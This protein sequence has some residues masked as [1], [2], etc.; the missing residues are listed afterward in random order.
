MQ[1]RTTSRRRLS[2]PPAFL[3]ALLPAVLPA[4]MLA[5][6][7]CNTN[8]IEGL[9]PTDGEE[10]MR[11]ETGDQR[12]GR[13]DS[14]CGSIK[15]E[16]TL[17]K[18]PVDIIFIIDNSGSMADEAL[19]VNNNINNNFANIIAASGLDYRVIMVT[20][21]GLYN[22]A[23]T[24]A[25]CVTKPLSTLA[26]CSPP[27]VQPGNNPPK[28]FHYSRQIE[29]SDSFTRLLNTYGGATPPLE[30]DEFNLAPGGWAM[31][32]RP[33]AFKVFI[34]ITDDESG[35]QDTVFE[36]RLFALMPKHFGDA[37]KRNYIFHAITGLIEN[38]PPTKPW[39]PGD[40]LQTVKCTK[41]GGAVNAGQI[42][43]K[44]AIATGGL[45]FPICE[46]AAFDGIFKEIANGVITGAK[47][48]CDFP[49]PEAP[50]GQTIDLGSVIVD[51]TPM[52]TG[53]PVEY[54][55]VGN[56]A[57]CV[58]NAFYIDKGRIYLCPDTCFGVQ[59]D[60]MAKLD[61]T[62]DCNFG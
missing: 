31:W 6:S 35:M 52:G 25:I 7:G 36:G 55:Q 5:S 9:E 45:R 23:S 40:P 13:N 39:G 44:L 33:E 42:Y 53:S 3:S 60:N 12:G 43:Q 26:T 58:P 37:M 49:L 11:K 28:F 18:K 48:S 46:H 54:K 50:P 10:D 41:G 30:K 24:K 4:A 15:A 21:H 51:Y 57:A 17:A 56:L 1:K 16:A 27:P 20:R 29:S 38:N 34:E 61:I 14:S 32:L 62:Y 2:L 59:Q 19:A 47:V 8:R 22:G